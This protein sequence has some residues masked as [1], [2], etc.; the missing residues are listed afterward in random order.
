MNAVGNP[1][2]IESFD[3]LDLSP[4]MLRSLKRAG[5]ESPTPIQ[6]GLIP[7]ALEGYDVIGQA[8]TGTGKTAAFSIPILEQ[9][10]PI[11]ECRDPQ[12]LIVVPT[13]ELADQVAGEAEKL[14]FGVQT[15]IAVLSGEKT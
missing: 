2:V 1:E 3:Q 12:A 13:R 6:A 7:L 15:E 14:G 4:V 5:Y 11:S 9:L 10:D 8:R